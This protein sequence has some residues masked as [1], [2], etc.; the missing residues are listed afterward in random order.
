MGYG[1]KK[2]AIKT[3]DKSQNQ[4]YEINMYI[5][6]KVNFEDD[7][8]VDQGKRPGE[9]MLESGSLKFNLHQFKK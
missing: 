8:M 3:S 7:V 9:S 5:I 1:R 6:M 4:L 2:R